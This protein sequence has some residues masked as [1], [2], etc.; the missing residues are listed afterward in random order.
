MAEIEEFVNENK[1]R[2]MEPKQLMM[3][4]FNDDPTR[5]E[6]LEELDKETINKM[7]LDHLETQGVL[8]VV[9]EQLLD[10]HEDITDKQEADL[11]E[12]DLKEEMGDAA[13]GQNTEG[14][15]EP[16]DE[17]NMNIPAIGS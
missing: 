12:R 15:S 6:E 1:L 4:L 2:M 14:K 10:P 9:P 5:K 17:G 16:Q 8:C 3:A 11:A 7:A 13:D